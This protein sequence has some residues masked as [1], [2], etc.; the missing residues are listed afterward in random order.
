MPNSIISQRRYKIL[1]HLYFL[2][3]ENTLSRFSTN[4]GTESDNEIASSPYFDLDNSGNVTAV[5]GKTAYLNCRVK[6]IKNQTVSIFL[7]LHLNTKQLSLFMT[8]YSALTIFKG[9]ELRKLWK[10]NERS[11][12]LISNCSIQRLSF[13]LKICIIVG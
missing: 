10:L 7:S 12:I 4:T 1:I 2:L 5:L 11:T 3:L 9:N 8:L 13:S 6:H